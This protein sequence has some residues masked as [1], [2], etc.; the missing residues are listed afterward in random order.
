MYKLLKINGDDY[1][2][3]YSIEA[4]L[5]ADCISSLT[6][7]LSDIGT[8]E[9]NKDIKGEL[10]GMS[11]VPSTTLTLFY[12]G[13]MEAHGSHPDGDGKV[14]DIQSAKRLIAAYIKENSENESGNFYGLMEMCINQ[15][16]EDGFFKLVG[17]DQMI[18][19]P[20]PKK[21]AQKVPED[22]KK[23]SDK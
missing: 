5:Y 17:L 18:N 16:A 3:Q 6:E 13:L 19:A 20:D 1:K 14:P 22:H 10:R 7:L 2:L 15:M 11:N 8:A 21:K 23:P 4:S 9:N 12:A